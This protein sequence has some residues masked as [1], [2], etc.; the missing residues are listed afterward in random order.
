MTCSYCQ[1]E[2]DADARFCKRCGRPQLSHEVSVQPAVLEEAFDVG[3]L[4]RLRE[5][6][7]AVSQ[8]LNAMLVRASGRPFTAEEERA[9][10]ALHARWKAAADELTARMD[11]LAAREAGDRRQRERRAEQ[12]RKQYFAIEIDERR[13]DDRRRRERRGDGDRRTPY[14]E[15]PPGSS[16]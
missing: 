7:R 10:H 15:S 11:Y 13:G 6:K 9:W 14:P 4:T 1:Q 5:E 2:N 3:A 8:Q 16:E 12:R